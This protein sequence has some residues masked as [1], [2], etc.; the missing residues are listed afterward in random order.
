[1]K[2]VPINLFQINIKWIKKKKKDRQGV[3]SKG[4]DNFKGHSLFLG[5][6]SWETIRNSERNESWMNMYVSARPKN[7]HN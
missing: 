4:E 5:R 1:M 3:G 6:R 2:S 7:F